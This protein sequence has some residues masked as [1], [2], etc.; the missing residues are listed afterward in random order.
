[1][2]DVTTGAAY[3]PRGDRR[4]VYV[5][6]PSSIAIH[7]LPDP[8]GE[9]DLRR[10]IDDLADAG[11]DTFVQEAYTQG[12]TTY[13]RCGRFDYDARLQHRRFL[14]LLDSGV[15]PLQVLLDQSHKRGMEFLAGV[16]INDNHGHVSVAQGVGAG[17]RFLVDNPHLQIQEAP[18]GPYY[19]LSTPLDFTHP[20]VREYVF[21]VV[22]ELARTFDVDGIELC[23]RDHRYFPPGRGADSQHLM[24]GLVRRVREMLD[25]LGPLRGR[26]FLLGARVYQTLD[27][28]HSQGLDVPGWITGG[29][30]D[31]VAPSDV[32][33][34]D[35]NAPYEQFTRLAREGDC[36]VY[37]GVLPW[38][39]V[40]MR[41]RL[42]EQPLSPEQLRALAQ[43]FYGAGADGVSFYNH[44]VPL[45]WAPFYPMMLF[46]LDELGDP[47][48]VAAGSRHYLFEPTWAG[49]LGFGEGRTSTGALKA[50]RIALKRGDSSSGGRYR[51]RVYEDV[52][53]ARRAMLLFRAYNLTDADEVRVSLNGSPVP[54][55][56]LGRR[57]DERRIDVA[58]PTDP[59]SNATLGLPLVAKAPSS[60]T[61]FWF[62]LTAP[63]FRCGENE[64]EVTLTESDPAGE[65]DVV[66]DEIEVFVAA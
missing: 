42:A 22:E 13:W 1:M 3:A 24:T 56:D 27:E 11:M 19:K 18:P 66:I 33:H 20:E 8:V 30:L 14:P 26:R 37:P 4:L 51:L 38:S 36:M 60:C 25:A 61:T 9:H 50:D 46:G 7:H 43:N 44:F 12:W 40:R 17:A 5:S 45:G 2:A 49:Q 62:R 53:N 59:S 23:F 6:D 21:S 28:C 32:M 31:Y 64:L 55:A 34:S 16:R 39:S 63:P 35:F 52:G 65:S 57:T 47:E 15:Q 10:W 48:R 54:D 29:L 41:R 58:A